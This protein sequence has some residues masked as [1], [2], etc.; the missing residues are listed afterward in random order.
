MDQKWLDLIHLINFCLGLIAQATTSK[1]ATE[2]VKANVLAHLGCGMSDAKKSYKGFCK[3]CIDF[4]QTPLTVPPGFPRV[5]YTLKDVQLRNHQAQKKN[6]ELKAAN[7]WLELL[8]S[9][10][11]K[12]RTKKS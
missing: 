10:I 9:E 2:M 1:C 7:A 12:R 11:P 8:E 4:C 6:W 3:I 5:Q